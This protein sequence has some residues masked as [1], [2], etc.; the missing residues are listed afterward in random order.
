[1]VRP[2]DQETTAIGK[3]A[4]YTLR[5]QEEGARH[6]MKATQESPKVSQNVGGQANV[7]KSLHCGFCRKEQTRKGNH[8]W[9][10][11]VSII[12]GLW[13]LGLSQVVWYLVL[14]D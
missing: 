4:C 11:L 5:S 10:R 8:A 6:A 1:M 2:I 3:V 12:S 13:G 7:G 9:D 14:G